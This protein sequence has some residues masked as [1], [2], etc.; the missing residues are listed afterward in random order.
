V[1]YLLSYGHHCVV[2][3]SGL[4]ILTNGAETAG[5]GQYLKLFRLPS[6]TANHHRSAARMVALAVHKCQVSNLLQRQ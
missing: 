1:L 4:T 6:D 5:W 2:L 3:K